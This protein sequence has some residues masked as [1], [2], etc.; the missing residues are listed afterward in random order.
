MSSFELSRENEQKLWIKT[1]FPVTH[2]VWGFFVKDIFPRF[3]IDKY[4]VPIINDLLERAMERWT[5]PE[6]KYLVRE[7]NE[8][9][10]YKSCIADGEGFKWTH[11]DLPDDKRDGLNVYNWGLIYIPNPAQFGYLDF[12]SDNLIQNSSP[13]CELLSDTYQK[14]IKTMKGLLLKLKNVLE[15]RPQTIEELRKKVLGLY[16][17][18]PWMTIL[19]IKTNT[20]KPLG[21]GELPLTSQHP[22]NTI[23]GQSELDFY[24][25]LDA[26]LSPDI[27]GSGRYDLV[28]G[29]GYCMD[30]TYHQGGL[31]PEWIIC[32][33]LNVLEKIVD[34]R[35]TASV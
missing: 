3:S 25:E 7:R 2:N 14:E 5:N 33:N 20:N 31:T 24:R 19:D 16:G 27:F 6:F 12:I 10:T 32:S 35:E 4:K 11:A 22:L 28:G 23:E 1:P 17:G 34:D 29:V 9:G 30:A 18:F 8:D 13:M 26:L 21:I 15:E